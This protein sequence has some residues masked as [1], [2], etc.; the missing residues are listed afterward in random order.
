MTFAAS[1]FGKAFVTQFAFSIGTHL[2]SEIG[3]RSLTKWTFIGYNLEVSIETKYMSKSLLDKQY[4]VM[5][6]VL[7][8]MH[9]YAYRLYGWQRQLYP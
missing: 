5:Y 7:R 6:P 2:Q 4:T 1:S 3:E 9:T 8:D